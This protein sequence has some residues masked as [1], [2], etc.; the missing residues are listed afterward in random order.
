[1][2][3]YHSL[4]A[5]TINYMTIFFFLM[6][7][8]SSLRGYAIDCYSP[9]Y[10]YAWTFSLCF[11]SM[12]DCRLNCD[13]FGLIGLRSRLTYFTFFEIAMLFQSKRWFTGIMSILRFVNRSFRNFWAMLIH[14]IHASLPHRAWQLTSQVGTWHWRDAFL[15][16]CSR[17]SRHRF[18]QLFL[19]V[20][21][22]I[23]TGAVSSHT[24]GF[25]QCCIGCAPPASSPGRKAAL[26]GSV[27]QPVACLLWSIDSFAGS[28]RWTSYLWEGEK[29]GEREKERE[30][31][32]AQTPEML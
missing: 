3:S 7:K 15:S 13:I 29:G 2:Y 22:L 17:P 20:F 27:K 24:E 18:R 32:R 11:S 19:R 5:V 31:N 12:I 14:R 10:C 23:V 6:C 8:G 9:S 25:L 4:K 21:F 1:M 28:E 26:C 30:R 16:K